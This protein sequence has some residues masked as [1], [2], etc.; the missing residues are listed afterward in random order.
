MNSSPEQAEPI[1]LGAMDPPVKRSRAIQLM[2]GLG[3][4]RFPVHPPGRWRGTTGPKPEREN[5]QSE[6]PVEHKRT[7]EQERRQRQLTRMSDRLLVIS[8]EFIPKPSQTFQPPLPTTKQERREA[9]K[10]NIPTN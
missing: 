10:A 8:K 1:N 6:L 7:Q 9:Q 3:A 2:D 4:F 5:L